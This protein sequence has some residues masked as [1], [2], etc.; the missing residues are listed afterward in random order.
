MT[1]GHYDDYDHAEGAWEH[2]REY[3]EH[4]PHP[5]P[6][7]PGFPEDEVDDWPDPDHRR[8]YREE[9]RIGAILRQ[10][11]DVGQALIMGGSA[12]RHG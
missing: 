5:T 4:G 2:Q 1:E 9:H 3:E 10:A 6:H 11:W 7:D 8:D 12:D